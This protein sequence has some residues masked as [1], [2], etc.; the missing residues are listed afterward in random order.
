MKHVATIIELIELA[1]SF[2]QDRPQH[3]A[4]N[5]KTVLQPQWT[6]MDWPS[7]SVQN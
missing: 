4:L 6:N 7:N 3:E 5:L 2:L 1:T